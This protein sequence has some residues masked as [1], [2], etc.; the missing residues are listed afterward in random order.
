MSLFERIFGKDHFCW[1]NREP[2][3]V[4]I[5]VVGGMVVEHV[6]KQCGDVKVEVMR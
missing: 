3:V 5:D 6:C 4:S 2:H 1:M